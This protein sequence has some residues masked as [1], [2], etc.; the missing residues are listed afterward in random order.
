MAT[1][2]V[3]G[4]KALRVSCE[5]PLLQRSKISK[6]FETL[7]GSRTSGFTRAGGAPG[8]IMWFKVLWKLT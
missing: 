1:V 2:G 3:K 4:G 5:G 8:P 6:V 7:R